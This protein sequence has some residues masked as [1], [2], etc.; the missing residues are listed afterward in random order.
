MAN[1]IADKKRLPFEVRVPN[2]A[3][4]KAIKELETGK[5]KRLDDIQSLMDE[6]LAK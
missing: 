2:A 4:K 5:G 1:G 6:L 3:T